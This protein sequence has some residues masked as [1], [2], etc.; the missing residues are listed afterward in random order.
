MAG[1][2]GTMYDQIIHKDITTPA[3]LIAAEMFGFYCHPADDPEGRYLFSTGRG[4]IAK[5]NPLYV[6]KST[7][8]NGEPPVR[9]ET[10]SEL[11]TMYRESSVADRYT[12]EEL[13]MHIED[14][15]NEV[16]NDYVEWEKT[17]F[18]KPSLQARQQGEDDSTL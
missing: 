12:P 17:Y 15:L 8:M 14:T 1:M 7:E 10:I 6:Q 5:F 16:A 3:E 2:T 11:D 18:G 9:K 13:A 4:L